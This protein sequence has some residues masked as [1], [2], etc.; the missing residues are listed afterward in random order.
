MRFSS[1]H[2]LLFASSILAAHVAFPPLI[3]SLAHDLTLGF[4]LD[5]ASFSTSVSLVDDGSPVMFTSAGV[6]SDKLSSNNTFS[7]PMFGYAATFVYNLQH[8]PVFN[9]NMSVAALI[10]RGAIQWWNDSRLVALNPAVTLP[11]QP[12]QV[13]IPRG[14]SSADLLILVTSTLSTVDSAFPANGTDSWP[15]DDSSYL[16]PPLHIAGAVMG[17]AD[18]VISNALSFGFA[19]ASGH[20]ASEAYVIH[21]G[22]AISATPSTVQLAMMSGVVLPLADYNGL[23]RYSVEHSSS[24]N[25]W[26]MTSI[27]YAVIDTSC[28]WFLI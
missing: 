3:S 5:E 28:L 19:P 9:V 12:I 1:L 11:Q 25:A 8:V 4:T 23:L 16:L 15:I 13:I 14:N 27:V 10:L 24:S 6:P 22:K 18:G 20:A 7:V 21:Q 26:P 17:S 2:L